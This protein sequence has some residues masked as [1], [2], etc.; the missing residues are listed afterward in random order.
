MWIITI[1]AKKKVDF[2]FP[3]NSFSAQQIGGGICLIKHKANIIDKKLY[4][5]LPSRYLP[6]SLFK[7]SLLH[8]LYHENSFGI[9]S[10]LVPKS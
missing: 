7:G 10:K 4:I 2:H 3:P 5:Y 9:L 1:S 8:I 6:I